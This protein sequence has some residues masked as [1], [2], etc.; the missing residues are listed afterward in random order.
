MIVKT[1]ILDEKTGN[2]FYEQ[3]RKTKLSYEEVKEKYDKLGYT[4]FG[5]SYE[6]IDLLLYKPINWNRTGF[7]ALIKE[8]GD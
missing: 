8:Q 1:W 4:K 6:G 7:A 3:E 2:K 5:R